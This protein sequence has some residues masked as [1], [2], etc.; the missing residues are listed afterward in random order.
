MKIVDSQLK[1][2][3][4][5]LPKNKPTDAFSILQPRNRSIK[6]KVLSELYKTLAPDGYKKRK[7]RKSMLTIEDS[8]SKKAT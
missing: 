6:T 4:D 5:I 7:A 1:S 3:F 8:I 2:I